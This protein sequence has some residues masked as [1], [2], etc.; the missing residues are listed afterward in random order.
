MADAFISSII[1]P[2]IPTIKLGLANIIILIVIYQY[3]YSAFTFKKEKGGIIKELL[4]NPLLISAV[5]GL[6]IYFFNIN[7]SI[8]SLAKE[9][10]SQLGFDRESF[11]EIPNTKDPKDLLACSTY[12]YAEI[13]RKEYEKDIAENPILA[14]YVKLTEIEQLDGGKYGFY[15]ISAPALLLDIVVKIV[16]EP[17]NTISIVKTYTPFFGRYMTIF[18]PFITDIANLDIVARA[19][20]PH[21]AGDYLVILNVIENTLI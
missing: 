20:V 10:M 17:L 9:V 1:L 19:C 14:K 3:T 4:T 5:I 7:S 2:F 12:E 16:D 11:Y 13:L 8:P 15:L 6:S 21:Y 18:T